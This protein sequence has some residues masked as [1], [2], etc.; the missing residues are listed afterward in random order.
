MSEISLQQMSCYD[1]ETDK[2]KMLEAEGYNVIVVWEYDWKHNP[3]KIVK[4]IADVANRI[5]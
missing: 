1:I 2:L 5:S 4:E 3:E